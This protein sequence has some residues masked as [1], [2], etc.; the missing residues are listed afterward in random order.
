MSDVALLRYLA[1]TDDHIDQAIERLERQSATIET[2]RRAGRD[3]RAAEDLLSQFECTL[4]GAPLN[5]ER[6][7]VYSKHSAAEPR[8]Q[9]SPFLANSRPWS[10]ST[11]HVCFTLPVPSSRTTTQPRSTARLTVATVSRKPRMGCHNSGWPPAA[12]YS[13]Y[14]KYRAA[15]SAASIVF[16]GLFLPVAI[17]K[18]LLT[19][20][21][22]N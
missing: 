20:T 9:R 22:H 2:L 17:T 1:Q 15:T 8:N 13:L 14:T 4:K 11:A 16:D 19:V 5:V 12:S 6:S 21:N 10:V 18:G 3:T 7:P